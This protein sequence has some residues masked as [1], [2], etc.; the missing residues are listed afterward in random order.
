MRKLSEFDNSYFEYGGIAADENQHID[1]YIN[2][3]SSSAANYIVTT[4]KGFVYATVFR[5][6]GDYDD[7]QDV[8]QEVF[9]KVL[10]N[11][12]KF[13]KNSSLKT[14]LYRIAANAAINHQRKMK[15]TRLFVRNDS[16]V[17]ENIT[18]E[19]NESKQQIDHEA[20]KADFEIAIQKLPK[21]QRET[22]VLRYY[23]KLTYEQISTML[24]TSVGGLKANYFQACK[25]LATY[26]KQYN[27]TLED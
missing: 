4:Y 25:K 7:A 1:D 20:F 24:G 5:Y 6:L 2:N 26:L 22:F 10:D 16:T 21:K 18:E 15:L 14:W 19:P 27:P 13:K 17:Y 12:H 11:L 23:E 8:T 3:Q 9:I